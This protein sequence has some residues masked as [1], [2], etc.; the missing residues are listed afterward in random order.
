[1]ED[2]DSDLREILYNSWCINRD[3]LTYDEE[4]WERVNKNWEIYKACGLDQFF[5]VETE[6]SEEIREIWSILIQKAELYELCG[7]P[8]FSE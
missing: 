7:I 6:E 3:G 4:Y 1:M 8:L 2:D 5:A